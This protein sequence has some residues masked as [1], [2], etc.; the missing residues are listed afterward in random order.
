MD[1]FVIRTAKPSTSKSQTQNKSQTTIVEAGSSKRL[2]DHDSESSSSDD[3]PTT[4][5]ASTQKRYK[6]KYKSSWEIDYTW[7]QC[8]NGS[9]F[10][11][12]C[13]K[14]LEN[15]KK[16]L[17]RHHDSPR[18]ISKVKNEMEMMS[19]PNLFKQTSVRDSESSKTKAE[20][21]CLMFCIKRN[22]SI[23]NMDFLPTLI[24]TVCPDSSIAKT[25]KCGRTKGTSM[26]NNIVGPF[27]QS[28]II[29]QLKNTKFSIII[30]ETTDVSSTKCLVIV[31][32]FF[33]N[34]L[35]K[36]TDHFFGLVELQLSDSQEI[37]SS[38]KLI[39]EEKNIPLTNILGLA[40]DNASV[41]SGSIGGVRAR[42]QNANKDIFFLGCTCHSL[43][44]CASAASKK[45]P[46]HVEKIVKA[47]YN[48][49]AHSPKRIGAYKEF[50][51]YFDVKSN[52]I[53]GLSSTRWL[54]MEGVVNRILQQWQPLQYYFNLQSFD[55]QSSCSDI[56]N[57]LMKPQ[58]KLYL[59]F[60]S[61]ILKLINHTTDMYFGIEFQQYLDS[62]DIVAED[63]IVI[64][65][66]LLQ[67]YKELCKQIKK[68]FDFNNKKI[69]LLKYLDVSQIV[70]GTMPSILPIL[71][72]FPFS[73]ENKEMLNSQWRFLL[74]N[75]DLVSK[76]HDPLDITKFWSGLGSIK[77]AIGEQFCAELSKY[78]LMLCSLPHS[79][80]AAERKFSLVNAVKTDLRNSLNT[81]TLENIILA[82]ELTDPKK[83]CWEPSD[84]PG[85][86]D[87][88]NQF[89]F[90]NGEFKRK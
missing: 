12:I 25:I 74:G 29:E 19:I 66:M 22:L 2:M 18:H 13:F 4:I 72:E 45:L 58:S 23:V 84:S 3:E 5:I 8:V 76:Y 59:L 55:N 32:R 9:G 38:L 37:F 64:K 40:T 26:L 62:Q 71:D 42:F 44:L 47:I 36:M 1:K 87:F 67:F 31:T 51:E 54:S 83:N 56:T 90:V 28:L 61:Y 46:E 48:Y 49:F 15:N 35:N 17:Q 24:S 10:C 41:M 43:H 81:K 88:F 34:V 65:S 80:A 6:Q 52:S 33:N 20:L 70:G 11:K 30:D 14:P 60:L 73:S 57:F 53:L 39:F 89:N 85:I 7:L 75:K 63:L 68:R 79:S 69:Q 82:K 16:N 27:A 77:N 86:L 21:T 50:Q 78:M